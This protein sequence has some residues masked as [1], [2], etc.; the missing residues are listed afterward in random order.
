MA[1]ADEMD[2]QHRSWM[3]VTATAMH[4]VHSASGYK[5]AARGPLIRPQVM[6]GQKAKDGDDKGSG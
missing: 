5:G 2:R 3:D 1:Q 6:T 4:R